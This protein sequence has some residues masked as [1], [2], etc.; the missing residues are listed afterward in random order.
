MP[1]SAPTFR[2]RG[3]SLRALDAAGVALALIV[4][5]S[6]AEAQVSPPPSPGQDS[7]TVVPGEIYEASGPYRALVG[8]GYRD[9]WTTPIR[10]PVADLG[11]LGGGLT[12]VE[13]GGGTTTQTLQLDGADGRRYVFRSVQ[14]SPRDLLEDL[15]GTPAAA[16]IQD[17]MSAF[18]PSAAMITARLLEAVNVL[19]PEPRLMV[20]PDDPRLG[21]FRE[22]FA[23]MLV[24]FEERPD[25]L[26]E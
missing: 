22:Q 7:V 9:L 18:H 14:K 13:L 16:I 15:E 10:V 3:N 5:A 19:H 21:E 24:L 20:V 4:W 17:Q 11:T 1:R 12:P 2:P 6:S 8:S 25:D 23:G 26:P